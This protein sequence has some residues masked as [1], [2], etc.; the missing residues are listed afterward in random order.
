MLKIS[1]AGCLG[2]SPTISS[3]FTVEMC[4][5][6][7][8]VEQNSLKPPFWKIQG[9]SR[10]SM[11]TNPKSPSPALVIL[12]S[13]SVPICNRF[14]TIRANSSKITSFKGVLLYDALVREK[15]PYQEARNF[16]TKN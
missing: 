7:K 16:V 15:P 11:F 2:L 14:H 5:G 10:S 13:K 8:N 1:Y 4:A 3:Q 6:A 12:C 9:R